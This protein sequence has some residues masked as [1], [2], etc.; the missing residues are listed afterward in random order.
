M[1]IV[2]V[3][4]LPKVNNLSKLDLANQKSDYNYE[5]LSKNHLPGSQKDTGYDYG[6]KSYNNEYSDPKSYSNKR[7]TDPYEYSNKPPS[8]P[9]QN[10]TRNIRNVQSNQQPQSYDDYQ[11]YSGKNIGGKSSTAQTKASEQNSGIR[12]PA[13]QQQQPRQQ[14]RQEQEYYND[15]EERSIKEVN[16][17]NRVDIIEYDPS[18]LRPCRVCGRKFNPDSINKHQAHCK[19]VFQK[20]RKEFNTQEQRIVD[21]Q[22]KKLM[23]RGEII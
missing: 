3:R 9:Q 22:Q 18:E 12:Q 21:N 7:Q 23:K 16:R 11:S 6:K 17:E 2:V 15:R 1:G 13:K 5:V 8:Y 19:Q 14:H 20:K 4:S 10:N